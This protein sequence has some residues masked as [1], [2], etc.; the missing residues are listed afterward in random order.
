MKLCINTETCIG[1]S[2]CKQIC[3]RDNLTIKNKKAIELNNPEC[4]E[5]GQ[6]IGICPTNSIRLKK[7]LNQENKIKKYE[8]LKIKPS[9][10]LN[11]LKQRRS[12]RWFKKDK[13]SKETF[14]K[15][16]EATYY[17][18]TAQNIQDVEFV[19]I[20]KQLNEF[21]QHIYNIIKK[22]ENKYLRIKQLGEYLQDKNKY[23]NNPLL[24]EGH[25]LILGF[26][27]NP[28][29]AI[30]ATTRLEL[31]AYTLGLGGFYSLFIQKADEINHEKLMEFFSKISKDKHMYSAFIIGYPR[32]K[33]YRT[34]PHKKIKI[35]YL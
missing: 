19:V 7:H 9:D 21:I 35:Q 26:S 14:D 23:K 22:E 27:S 6:C 5:C 30:I 34:V 8:K 4:F 18:P 10:Y 11:L 3:I 20:D 16:F 25:Q 24:W 2:L 28:A 15:L 13:I 31:Y 33:Y 29:N 17:S 1:C 12:I 32:V